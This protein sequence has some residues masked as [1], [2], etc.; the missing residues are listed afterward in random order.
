VLIALHGDR[1]GFA[2]TEQ[3]APLQLSLHP[4]VSYIGSVEPFFS[5]HRHPYTRSRRFRPSTFLAYEHMFSLIRTSKLAQRTLGAAR[6]TRS[7]LWLEDDYDVD[8]EVDQ[9]QRSAL[10]HPHRAALRRGV[11]EKR[12]ARRRPGQ[13]DTPAQVCVSPV[14][15]AGRATVGALGAGLSEDAHTDSRSALR[16]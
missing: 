9:D 7:F 16:R 1:S 2:A 11:I 14:A 8:W 13:P 15:R 4:R 10:D 12:L 3:I 6:L 5:Q